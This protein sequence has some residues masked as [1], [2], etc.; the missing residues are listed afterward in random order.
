[1]DCAHEDVKAAASE[2]AYRDFITVVLVLDVERIF[3]D[4]WIYIH[5]PNVRLGR[6]QNFKNWSP[7]MTPDPSKTS[8]GLEYFCNEG[9]DLWNAEDGKLIEL[10][11]SEL[12]KIGLAGG[13]IIKGYVVRV[14][15]AYPV[16]NRDYARRIGLVREYLGSVGGLQCIGRNG[17]HRY[18]NMDHSMMTALIAA[19]NI[20]TDQKRD[21]WAVNEDAKYLEK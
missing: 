9:D 5:A 17:Q 2:L 4:N 10:G 6:I 1:M 18:N 19:R 15:K 20:A 11:Y 3:P 8:L 14:R 7:G 12:S 16:Y 13:E 21:C